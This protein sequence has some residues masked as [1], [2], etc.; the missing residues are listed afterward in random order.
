MDKRD[1]L[2]HYDE[3]SGEI[4]FH[5]VLSSETRELRAKSFGGVRPEVSY[6]KAL[7][8]DEAEQALGRLVF[9]LVDLNSNAK[10][11]IRDYESEADADHSDY[12]A[13]LEEEVKA[14]DIEA[15]FHL[16]VEM[17]RSAMSNCSPADLRRAEELL[18]HAAREGHE[19][20]KQWLE[21]T[22]PIL[23]AAAERSI[24]RGNSV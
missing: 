2:I 5:S 1:V 22:W 4:I 6:F 23:K 12:V 24:A 13:A 15:S 18:N 7:S 14:G 10:I 19:K 8:P 11:G 3:E 17:H 9:H 21:S 16:G 20:A